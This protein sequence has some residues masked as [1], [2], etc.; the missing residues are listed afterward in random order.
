MLPIQHPSGG[1]S[2]A[3]ASAAQSEWLVFAPE[4]MCGPSVVSV[5]TERWGNVARGTPA[6]APSFSAL[7]RVKTC[8]APELS[9]DVSNDRRGGS[10]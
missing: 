2:G 6:T 5:D 1:A 7:A 8:D 4:A 9:E 10:G 3:E